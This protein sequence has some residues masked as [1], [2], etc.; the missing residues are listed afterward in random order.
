M[1]TLT[2]NATVD[3]ARARYEQGTYNVRFGDDVWKARQ[4]AAVVAAV[5]PRDE[6]RSYADIGCGSGG[7]MLRLREE[8]HKS[9]FSLDTTVGYDIAPIPHEVAAADRQISFKQVDFLNERRLYDLVTLNDVIE[10][11]TQPQNLLRHVAE[12]SRYIALHIPLDDRLSV[13]LTNQYNYRLDTVGHISFWNAAAA[14]NLL[15]FAGL[16]PL[17]CRFTPGFLAPSGRQR[18]AQRA[19]IPLRRLMWAVSPPLT[20]RVLGGVSL[21]IVCRGRRSLEK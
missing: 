9:G 4:I 12:C 17:H 6:I 18:P 14:I 13:T 15:T 3:P 19:L 11:V 7:V 2:L 5:V 10:H 21:A 8:L 16:L 20:A 1:E